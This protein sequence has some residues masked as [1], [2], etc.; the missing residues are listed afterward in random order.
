MEASP[1]KTENFRESLEHSMNPE[2]QKVSLWHYVFSCWVMWRKR[3]LSK[4]DLRIT[5]CLNF[6]NSTVRLL[7][8]LLSVW[9]CLFACLFFLCAVAWWHWLLM[10][11]YPCVCAVCQGNWLG[12]DAAAQRKPTE[13]VPP[14]SW[15]P[16]DYSCR[17]LACQYQRIV[18]YLESFTSCLYIEQY[19]M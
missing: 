11:C 13:A 4:G 7:M 8:F 3:M 17:E 9:N 5:L 14:L 19:L 10:L 12:A 18:L 6:W 1:A 16:G 15:C 2:L